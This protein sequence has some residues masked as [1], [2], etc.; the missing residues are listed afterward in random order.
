MKNRTGHPLNTN[1]QEAL[2]PE[3][4]CSAIQ[5]CITEFTSDK[6]VKRWIGFNWLRA[7][8]IVG[9]SESTNKPPN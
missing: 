1:T 5:V 7:G 4:T 2:S 9:F 8:L 6:Y 3:P